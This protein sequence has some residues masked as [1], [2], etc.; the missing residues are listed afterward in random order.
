M[1]ARVKRADFDAGVNGQNLPMDLKSKLLNPHIPVAFFEMVPPVAGKPESLESAIKEVARIQKLAD[2]INLPEIHDESRTGDRTFKFVPRMEPGLLGAKIRREFKIEIVLNRCVVYEA[3]QVR[4]FREAQEKFDIRNFV[5]VG[6]E[7]SRIHYPGPNVIQAASQV[8]AAGLDATLGG[9]S[10]PSRAREVERI[11]RKVAEGLCFFTT[12]VLFDSNDI[13][14]LIQRLNGLEA[15]IFLSF[16]PVSHHR[17]VEFLRW[18]GAD[19]PA[20]LDRFLLHGSDK[21]NAVGPP[22]GKPFERCLNL[23]KRILMDVYDNLP[24]DPP[25]LGL[26]IEHINR[27]NFNDAVEMLEQLGAFFASLVAARKRTSLV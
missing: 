1:L 10:I 17:D 18:L 21:T 2:A 9:I 19:V 27:R 22:A 15:R 12:Q 14:W 5:L 11:R 16:A 13:V 26:N 4:W 8:R 6:G 25:P 23:A 20:D 3:E 7:S 24:P